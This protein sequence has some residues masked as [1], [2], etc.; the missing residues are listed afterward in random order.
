MLSV[1]A[2][3]LPNS[4]AAVR[5]GTGVW[6]IETQCDVKKRVTFD[7]RIGQE[8]SVAI[9]G[10]SAL[11]SGECAEV[12]LAASDEQGFAVIRVTGVNRL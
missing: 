1:L 12:D 4:A 3:P 8:A 5:P 6:R 9:C 10:H 11:R 7:D 2:S